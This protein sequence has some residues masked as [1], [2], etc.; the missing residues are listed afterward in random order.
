MSRRERT[1]PDY[2]P[3]RPPRRPGR[4]PH[5]PPPRSRR[6]RAAPR[7]RTPS[8]IP[9]S[10]RSPRATAPPPAASP[11]R[12][13]STSRPGPPAS[14][15]SPTT[16]PARAPRCAVRA[17]PTSA[18]PAAAS[19]KHG[20]RATRCARSPR[21]APSSTSRRCPTP[22]RR[23]PTAKAR[24]RPAPPH[25]T[26]RASTA[27]GSRWRSSISASPISPPARRASDIPATAI[28]HSEC[29]AGMNGNT[30]HGTAVAEI[31]HEMAP[32]AQLYLVCIDS[33]AALNAA[34]NFLVAQDVSIA[35]FSVAFFNTARGDGSGGAGTPDGIVADAA[36][37]GILWVNSAG[38]AA[39]THYQGTFTDTNGNTFHNFAGADEGSDVSIA[40]GD[41]GCAFLRWDEWPGADTDFDL[42]LSNPANTAY[43][44]TSVNSQT[45]TQPPVEGL[46]FT[47]PGA[48]AT[49][50]C[51][52]GGSPAPARRGWTSSPTTACSHTQYSV[53]VEQ[54]PRP[55]RVDLGVHRRRDLLPE[56]QPRAVLVAGPDDRRP[57]QAG[58]RR[59]GRRDLRRLRGVLD[60]RELRLHRH[61]RRLA[62]HRGRGRAGQGS[63]PEPHRDAAAQLP[64][65]PRRRA[66]RRGPGRPVRGGQVAARR[67]QPPA[68]RHDRRGERRDLWG[69]DAG[70]HGQPAGRRDELPV[71]VRPDRRLRQPDR[72]GRRRRGH[73]GPGRLRRRQRA[74]P[75]DDL[76]LP[77]RG[78]QR[79]RDDQRRRRHLHH[80]G[81]PG[82]RHAPAARSERPAGRPRHRLE[83]RPGSGPP[84]RRQ[85]AG[86]LQDQGQEG[87]LHGEAGEGEAGDGE[88]HAR[89]EG[90]RPRVGA[91]RARRPPEGAHAAA[92][93]ARALQAERRR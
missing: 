46:C 62:A 93:G 29:A 65:R 15:C 61:L 85:A 31:V 73:L 63:E 14:A 21:R 60:L 66:R 23:P 42:A 19:W 12:A 79:P 13:D 88:A 55:R 5:P 86:D 56:R 24:P 45:G 52:S 53:A 90:R 41:T 69:R 22:R 80:G 87:D 27:P 32:G 18:P 67:A 35:N 83:R 36:S 2:S 49:S 91:G 7:T 6:P 68:D 40:P 43:V 16:S 51:S 48:T 3:S 76:P 34:K 1:T 30:N 9:R 58:H 38:N 4:L 50:T 25:G 64:P 89:R 78:E 54:H 75:I 82:D 71:P 92:P 39:Q 81:G 70:G 11:R 28:E 33:V 26:P 17:R 59:P 72:G 77:D 10:S 20:S 57:H 8:S 47:N 84:R 37:E 44:A 74:E